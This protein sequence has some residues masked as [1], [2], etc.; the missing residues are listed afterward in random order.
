MT[1]SLNNKYMATIKNKKEP[2]DILAEVDKAQKAPPTPRLRRASAEEKTA[3][4]VSAV[5]HRPFFIIGGVIFIVIIAGIAGYIMLS[6]SVKYDYNIIKTNINVNSQKTNINAINNSNIS[7]NANSAINTNSTAKIT[8]DTDGDGLINEDEAKAGTD[9][10][11]PD[12]DNDGLSDREEVKTWKTN[13]LKADTDG[14]GYNDGEE[15]KTLN[16][17]KVPGGKLLDLNKAI[18]QMNMNK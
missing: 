6:S 1:A 11:N 14:D 4:A 3:A 5:S 12:T 10:K 17:P 15:I 18:Q 9:P 2:E 8:N 13:P 7:P 16:D